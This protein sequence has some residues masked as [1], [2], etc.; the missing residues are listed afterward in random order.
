MTTNDDNDLSVQAILETLEVAHAGEEPV[1]VEGLRERK[2]QR[3]RQRIS[4][5]AT[6]LFL[7]EG[8]DN[9]TVARIAAVSEVSEQTVFN[10]FPTKES[11][12]FDRSESHAEALAEAVR[13]RG[14]ESLAEVVVN[15][16][17]G[18]IPLDRWDGMDE[19]HSLRLFRRFCEV[20]E[21]SP[22]LRAAPY[23]ELERFTA[24]VGASLAERV[25]RDCDDPEVGLTAIVIAGLSRVWALATY[26]HVHKVSSLAELERAV[27]AD[28]TRAAHLAAPTLDA[29][30]N[31]DGRT[32]TGTG[33]DTIHVHPASD[34]AQLG[35]SS[36]PAS[37]ADYVG[38]KPPG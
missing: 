17:F 2:K 3:A 27:R 29:F 25:G 26:A 19:A 36:P 10:Y 35:R 31:L 9:V 20:A 8:F 21:S 28:V 18:G 24:T 30:D 16:L 5:V 13:H 34:A 4:N 22:T 11:M 38:E 15:T 33:G 32:P 14:P 12:F 6:A 7:A 1:A 23:I 37:A